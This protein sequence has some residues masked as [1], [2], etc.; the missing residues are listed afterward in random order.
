[1]SQSVFIMPDLIQALK[2]AQMSGGKI[3]IVQALAAQNKISTFSKPTTSTAPPISKPPAVVTTSSPKI[4]LPIQKVFQ[5]IINKTTAVKTEPEPFVGPPAPV[6]TATPTTP[7]KSILF[8]PATAN[9]PLGNFLNKI[10]TLK[11]TSAKTVKTTPTYDSITTSIKSNLS[12]LTQRETEISAADPGSTFKDPS[13]K[14]YT[15]EE[16]LGSIRTSK[17]TLQNQLSTISN[18]QS[19]GYNVRSGAEG[20]YEFFKTP[21]QVR[22]EGISAKEKDLRAA[23]TGSGTDRLAG[24]GVWVTTGFLSWEDPLGL[25]SMGQAIIG[26]PEGALRTKATAAYDL[27]SAL[28]EGPLQYTL[29]VATG[30]FATV[31]MAFAGGAGVHMIEGKLA[32]SAT[33]ATLLGT[34]GAKAALIKVSPYIFKGAMTAAGIGFGGMMAKDVYETYQKDPMLAFAKGVTYAGSIYAGYKGYQTAG[35]KA[36]IQSKIKSAEDAFYDAHPERIRMVYMKKGVETG[37]S[38]TSKTNLEGGGKG[39]V[40]ESE[41]TTKATGLEYGKPKT[42]IFTSEGGTKSISRITQSGSKVYKPSDEWVAMSQSLADKSGPKLSIDYVGSKGIKG[43]EFF[44]K[45]DSA[46]ARPLLKT[47][48]FTKI[49]GR[50]GE[51]KS[52]FSKRIVDFSWKRLEYAEDLFASER[53]GGGGFTQTKTIPLESITIGE[54]ASDIFFA[55]S[56][57]L[58]TFFP[59]VAGTAGGSIATEIEVFAPDLM[60]VKGSGELRGPVFKSE[61]DSDLDFTL[62]TTLPSTSHKQIDIPDTISDVGEDF[63]QTPIQD[64]TF[65][66]IHEPAFD[67]VTETVQ[68]KAPSFKSNYIPGFAFEKPGF[69][70]SGFTEEEGDWLSVFGRTLK[71]RTGDLEKTLRSFGKGF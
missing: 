1:M 16:A 22:E 60:K 3:T 65:D 36:G 31:G 66:T 71:F 70:L 26:D 9:T 30:P 33:T 23:M 67:L 11:S 45:G 32:A 50:T 43:F 12:T 27:D 7:A 61:V 24:L 57:G 63:I 53:G 49:S 48:D 8:S 4:S 29:K 18:Y 52:G 68:E 38:I 56:K 39:Q 44:S 10:Q 2:T 51:I 46:E 37:G 42:E 58:G 54:G 25:K 35:G 20:S 28:K 62:K 5:N 6:K 59:I 14:E 47:L 34:T 19:Q 21:E 40:L 13:G 64:Q 41:L 55:P 69:A 15:K 17:S